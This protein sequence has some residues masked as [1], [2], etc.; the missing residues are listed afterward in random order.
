[1]AQSKMEK[2]DVEGNASGLMIKASAYIAKYAIDGP[3]VRLRPGDAGGS[4]E[5]PWR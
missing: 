5:E 3:K 4:Q 2:I 1:M